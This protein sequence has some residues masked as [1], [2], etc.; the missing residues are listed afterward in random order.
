MDK[1]LREARSMDPS[2]EAKNIEKLQAKWSDQEG[3]RIVMKQMFGDSPLANPDTFHQVIAK[4]AHPEITAAAVMKDPTLMT[5]VKAGGLVTSTY[6][7][8]RL[9][10]SAATGRSFWSDVTKHPG[11]VMAAMAITFSSGALMKY[12]ATSGSAPLQ[13]AM[14]RYY[15]DPTAANMAR[16]ANQLGGAVTGS[17]V[18]HPSSQIQ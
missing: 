14:V 7:L 3:T 11:D 18:G 16:Y 2:T 4:A 17:L 12:A 8:M 9:G 5:Y 13:R 15:T 1:A 10:Y 6:F